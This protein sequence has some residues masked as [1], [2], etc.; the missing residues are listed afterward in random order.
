M[1]KVEKLVASKS[2]IPH[3]NIIFSL[4][5][6]RA[7]HPRQTRTLPKP[8]NETEWQILFPSG[9]WVITRRGIRIVIRKEKPSRMKSD[10]SGTDFHMR[11]ASK[12]IWMEH[13]Q[14]ADFLWGAVDP[15]VRPARHRLV[16]DP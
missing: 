16:P 15:D 13:E 7:G 1:S 2:H 9:N 11:W 12:W 8:M 3:I 10:L 5:R 4:S 6:A 14:A